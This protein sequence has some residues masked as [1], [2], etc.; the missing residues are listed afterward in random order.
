MALNPRSSRNGSANNASEPGGIFQGKITLV[1]NDG[2]LRVFVKMLG[3]NIGPCRIVGKQHD[4]EFVIGDEVLV[5]YLDNQK[6]EMVVIGRLT[7]RPGAEAATTEPIGHEDKTESTISFNN[8]TRVFTIAPVGDSF[9]VWCVGKRYTKTAAESI[10]LPDTTGLYY[11]YYSSTGVLSSKTSFFTWDQDAPTA[12]IYYN[13]VT[14][15]AEFFA[16]E[17]HG[18]TL[19]WATHEYLHRTRGASLAEGLGASGYTLAGT[20]SS[21]ADMQI[22]IENGT[23]FDEDLEVNITHSATPNPN[24]WEQ[25]LQSPAYIPMFYRFGSGGSWRLDTATAYPVKYGSARAT[26][27]LS[28]GGTWS[29]PDMTSGKFGVTWIVAT[30]NLNE[31]VIGILGQTV[32]DNIGQAEDVS[33]ADLDLTGL[34][35]VEIRPLYKLI[36]ETNTGYTNAV[37]SR[38]ASIADIRANQ[39]INIGIGASALSSLTDV[40]LTTTAAND[41]LAY[42]GSNWTNTNTPTFQSATIIG[43]VTVDTST[44][45]V[46]ATNNRVGIGTVSPSTALEVVGTV[47]ATAF[48]GALTG[49]VSGT[50]TTVITNANLTGGV[51]SVGNAATVVTNANLTGD[52]T[53][54]GNATTLTNAPVIAKV[55]TGYVSG[56]GTVAATDSILQAIQ[57][58][59]GNNALK[60]D[61]ASPTFT[62]TPTLPTGTIATTQTAADSSTKVATTAFVTTAD[63]LKAN[64]ASPTFTGVPLST[65]AA[66]DTNTTQIATTAYVVGQGYAK[67]ASPTFTGTVSGITKTMV[68]LG[69]VDNT[70]DTAKPVSTAQQTALDLKANIA[71]PTFT[72]TVTVPTPTN[73]TDAVT[74]AYADA[75]TQSLDIKDSVR[76]ASTANIVI[77][78]ALINGSTIDGVVVAT[79]NRVLLKN[80]TTASENGIYVVVASGVASR[81]TD[82]N[83]SAKVTSGMYVFV[84]EGTVSANMGY[85]LTTDDTIT[86]GTTS[87][88]FTQFSG[89]GQITAG[90]GL[91]KSG[92]TLSINTAVTADLTTAQT[93]TNKTLTSPVLT[94]PTLG[95]ASATTVNK[96]TLTPPAT[97]ATLTIADGKTLTASNTLTL[98][99]TD[100]SSVAF[101]AGGTVAYTNVAT[102]SSLTSVGTLTNL[103]VT[104]AING[105]LT[106]TVTGT[107]TADLIYGNMA[108]NDQFRIR[109][110]GT[111]TN[112]G[113]VEIATADDGTEPIYVRQYTGVFTTL[114]RT[115]TLLDGSG[116]T[117]FPGTVTAPTF[118]GGLAAS[119]LT[120]QT[121]MWTSAGRPGATRLYRNDYDDAYNVQTYWTGSRWRLYG[122]LNNTAHADTHVGYADSAGSASTA[123]SSNA[124][125]F[126]GTYVRMS[127]NGEAD[128]HTEQG[129]QS[130]VG[131]AGAGLALWASGVAPQLRVGAGNNT[132][133]LR[134]SNDT[135]YV[136]IEGI[137]SNVSSVHLK[138][139]IETFPQIPKSIGS[140]VNDV[141]LLTGLNIVRQLRPVTYKWKEDE[142][143]LQLPAS[144]RRALALARL[145]K[146]RASQGLGPY[147]SDELRHDCSRDDCE[148]TADN[149]CQW[150]KNWEIGNIGFIS[151]EVGAVI[152]QA[153][154]LNKDEEFT[155]IDSL[156]MTALAVAAIKELDAKVTS[157]MER[158]EALEN[159]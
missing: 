94:T 153:A 46:D 91:S 26:Y 41:I 150:T 15:E 158:I 65:T 4:E 106:K 53:S 10:T 90:T 31:P 124:T 85:V 40:G 28:S 3:I 83:T 97:A 64:I 142:H 18:V 98:T 88:T 109:I 81:S 13:S 93:F 118:S 123:G 89:A 100:A 112:A 138:Q 108:D 12:Y 104:N 59:N 25:R 143:F 101:G 136:T 135:A 19:D 107:N 79:G 129:L 60:A 45:S 35:I 149:P 17:R 21:N 32:S 43:G 103:T 154:I 44:F 69:S 125:T 24:T 55:L 148:G 77:A 54:I 75:I 130:G 49:N 127:G 145:N 23:F 50:A 95:V 48:T 140:A 56:A 126:T 38:L 156:A 87:L 73:S 30:N 14:A 128:P 132:I 105:T 9:N 8:G 34:P 67:L 146:I 133:Y 113:Y 5:A 74:K 82:A 121:G 92:N 134:N 1:Y 116:N 6:S 61:I 84:S 155:S 78:S 16:D 27:N 11:I 72:G 68:G 42:N 39:A 36:Y 139:D 137:I 70:A 159:K 7:D 62:G 51:T 2:S 96:I 144:P 157:L 110:G 47:T 66:I 71:S 120:G 119:N 141:E 99:G 115:A 57:K 52:V 63:N 151:Q 80:Q 102:L 86:L 152:P 33:Y 20:G 122:Y 147:E 22:S 117:S 29:T 111:A 114:T 131:G 58:L 76:V 37:K